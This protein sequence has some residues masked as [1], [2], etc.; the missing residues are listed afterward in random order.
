MVAL[1]LHEAWSAVLYIVER[2]V[3]MASIP[4]VALLFRIFQIYCFRST[5]SAITVI[6]RRSQTELAF[7]S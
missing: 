3:R 4:A 1:S 5:E 2:H 6:P 7:P